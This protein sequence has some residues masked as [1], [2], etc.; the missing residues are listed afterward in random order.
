MTVCL[1]PA[2]RR[3]QSPPLRLM[4]TNKQCPIFSRDLLF[5]WCEHHRSLS[6][7]ATGDIVRVEC[8]AEKF[9]DLRYN[10]ARMLKEINQIERS[11]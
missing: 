2:D 10:V 4:V 7:L 8:S 5:F 6:S 1:P 3:P 11:R 9:Q